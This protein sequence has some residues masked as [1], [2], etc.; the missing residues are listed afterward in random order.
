MGDVAGW[1]NHGSGHVYSQSYARG[2][3]KALVGSIFLILFI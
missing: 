1:A 3:L 2:Y